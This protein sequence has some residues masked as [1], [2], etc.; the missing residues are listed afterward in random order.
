MVI[1]INPDSGQL[2]VEGHYGL[3]LPLSS[4]L[5][6]DA[7]IFT[8]IDELSELGISDTEIYDYI[9]ASLKVQLKTNTILNGYNK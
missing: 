8:I 7:G 3:V 5:P 6:I 2:I 1:D 9:K 4:K